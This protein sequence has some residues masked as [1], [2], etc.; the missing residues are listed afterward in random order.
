MAH[1]AD[2]LA[3]RDANIPVGGFLRAL[4]DVEPVPVIW[5]GAT[6]AAHVKQD[7]YERIAGE[8]LTA[9]RLNDFDAVYLDLHG[10]M[11]CTP[12]D[13]GEGRLL[14]ELRHILRPR[15]YAVAPAADSRSYLPDTAGKARPQP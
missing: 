11:V 8:I 10:A 12:E 7:A 1:G 15:H 9:A 3:L 4:P 14:S 2:L 6:P 13:D 5:A